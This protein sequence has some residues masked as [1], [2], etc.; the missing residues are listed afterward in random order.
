MN[1]RIATRRSPLALWQANH[2]ASLL[3]AAHPGITTSL[4]PLETHADRRLD[5]SI[6]ELGGKGAFSKEIQHQVLIG[7]ADIAVHSGKDLQAL[8]PDGLAIGA[9]PERGDARDALVGCTLDDLQLG[10]RVG[11]GS[12]R[13]R[14]QLAV[15]RPDL[16]IDGIRGNIAKRLSLLGEFDAIVMAG[17]A[18]E[19]LAISDHVVELLDPSVMIPQVAQGAL[20]IECRADD[21]ATFEHLAAI[22]HLP[23]HQT[24]AAERAFL[25]ELGG[26]CDLPAGAHCVRDGSDFVITGMLADDDDATGQLLSATLRGQDGCSLGAD[27]AR[28]LRD[29]L[30]AEA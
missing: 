13:R 18:L 2:V 14:V 29:E 11:T 24:V 9:V 3:Q 6:S 27:L 1:I 16:L 26:D 4:I 30:A 25:T 17:V 8:T 15:Q 12:N 22:D 5:I 21:Q 10:A 7:S 19:R 28:R 20:I 23:S